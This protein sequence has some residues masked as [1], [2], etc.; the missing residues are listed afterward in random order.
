MRSRIRPWAFPALA[1]LGLADATYLA[2]TDLMR[3][4]PQ[5]GGYSGCAEVNSSAF[6]FVFGV[7]V[8]F[9]GAGLYAALLGISLWRLRAMGDGRARATLLLY[10]LT[11]AGALFMAYLTGVEFFILGAVCYWCL[12]MATITLLLLALAVV[13]VWSLGEQGPGR[14]LSTKG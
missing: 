6:A 1:A 9:P 10:G 4:L 5:C 2:V 11:L 13:E 14:T 8:A 12:G 7:P 3:E